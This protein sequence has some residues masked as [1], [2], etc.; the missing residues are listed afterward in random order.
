MSC[1]MVHIKP[2][3][4]LDT[5]DLGNSTSPTHGTGGSTVAKLFSFVSG[6]ALVVKTLWIQ[7]NNRDNHVNN[8]YFAAL[9][10]A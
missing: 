2:C 4:T 7:G 8:Q 1:D 10:I 6:Y 3:L 5:F 9:T